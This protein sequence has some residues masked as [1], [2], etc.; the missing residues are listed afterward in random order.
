MDIDIGEKKMLYCIVGPGGCG[1]TTIGRKLNEMGYTSPESYT[2]RPKR[3]ETERG[4]LFITNDEYNTLPNKIAE[5]TIN[6]YH[7]CVTK[8]QLENCDFFIVEPSGIRDLQKKNVPVIIIGLFLSEDECKNRMKERGDSLEN[9][10]NRISFDK[11][12]FAH[13]EEMCDYLIDA[14]Q[15]TKELVNTILNIMKTRQS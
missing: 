9:I 7:Y 1:K 13:Y 4:H 12:A 3:K 6:G 10:N 5:V 11:M 2:T 15:S 8:E 14:N